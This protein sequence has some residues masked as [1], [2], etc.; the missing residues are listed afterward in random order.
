MNNLP[1]WNKRP[2]EVANLLNPAYFSM[3]INKVCEGYNSEAKDDLPYALAFITLPLILYPDYLEVLPKTSRT[4]LH[5][6]AQQNP[7]ILY[8]FAK[9]ARALAPHIR[10]AISF[11]ALHEVIQLTETGKILSQPLKR[12][13]SLVDSDS[14]RATAKQAYVI[15]KI[16][17]QVNDVPTLFAIFGACP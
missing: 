13:K 1:A 14:P 15:G 16:F 11:G 6:W 2:T 17:G 9:R 5:I 12:A 10:E 4:R 8:D 3:L 7:E